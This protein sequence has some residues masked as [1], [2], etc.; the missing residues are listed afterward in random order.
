ME[1]QHAVCYGHSLS[2]PVRV[3]PD[4]STG[5]GQNPAIFHIQPHPYL[6]E[7]GC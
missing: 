5:P 7:F 3:V 2:L 6:A 4:T 1:V